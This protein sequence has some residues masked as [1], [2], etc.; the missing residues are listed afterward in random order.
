M[1]K[2]P[3][4]FLC[5]RIPFPPNKGDK[6]ATF[7]LL[8][9]LSKRYQVHLGYFI[10]D[11]HDLQYIDKLRPYCASSFDLNI[12]DKRQAVSGINALF[13][14]S[15]IST[16]HYR[17]ASFQHWVDLTIAEFE[18]EKLYV[19]SSAMAQFIDHP[20]YQQ[21]TRIL[22][23]TDI[24]SDKWR[25]YAQAKPWY[26]KWVYA[27]EHRQLGKY[28]QQVLHNF[29]AVTLVTPQETELFC[30]M[31]PDPLANKIHTLTNGVDTDYFNP[32]ADF[33]LLATSTAPVLCFTGAMDYWANVDAMLWFCDNIWPKILQQH[34]QCKFYIVGGNPTAKVVALAER[35]GITVT[36]RVPDVRPYLAHCHLVIAPMRIARGVQNKVLEAMAMAK[37]VVMTS[38][39]QEGIKVNEQQQLLVI[40]DSEHM[41]QSI[42]QLL[43]GP[44]ACY[45]H[46]RQWILNHYSWDG[47]LEPLPA[48]LDAQYC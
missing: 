5:H 46:N 40:D 31:S 35:Q 8:K 42:N 38:M 18:I 14:G 24:D 23:M 19:Y 33:K 27:R 47:A 43:S 25:Q 4:L 34:P 1:G 39:A 15:S 10:D 30:Q 16:S 36:G 7:N 9:Y 21:K 41:A 22:N 26:S 44:I 32:S 20:R 3:L 11:Q 6:I 13:S 28:E 12:C 37:P 45:E 2:T 48:L 29:D 17:S